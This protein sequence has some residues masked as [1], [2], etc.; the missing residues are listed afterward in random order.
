MRP[1]NHWGPQWK[2]TEAWTRARREPERKVR[3]ARRRSGAM[4]RS[5][6]EA[7]NMGEMKEAMLPVLTA[8]KA[9]SESPWD[10]RTLGKGTA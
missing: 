2:W 9:Q 3:A 4:R 10:L 7:A 8:R 6:R 5:A 1:R